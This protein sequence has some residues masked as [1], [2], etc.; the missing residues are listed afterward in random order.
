MTSALPRDLGRPARRMFLGLAALALAGTAAELAIGRHWKTLIQEIPW[1][2]IGL[3]TIALLLLLVRP[4]RGR[5]WLARL[6]AAGVIVVA[7]VGVWEHVAANY[8]AGTL[9]F[10]YA[11]TWAS[12][13]WF[14]RWRIAATGGVGP[15]PVLAPGILAQA[16]LCLLAATFRHPALRVS[17]DEP[18]AAT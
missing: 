2:G 16:A 11:D 6:L 17:P 18:R 3:A 14:S 9:D 15:S 1:L 10:R 4:S 8:D 12:M 13:S 5:V 7:G